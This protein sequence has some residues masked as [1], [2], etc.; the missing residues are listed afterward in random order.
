MTADTIAT[1]HIH[2]DSIA[3]SIAL[4]ILLIVIGLIAL[5][6]PFLA[7]VAFEAIVAWLLVLGGIGHLILAWHVRGAGHHVWE[8]LI[9]VAYLFA[10]IY[11]FLHPVAGLIGLTAILGAYLL[12]KGIFELV[13]GLQIRGARGSGWLIID[14]VISLILA[15]LIWRHLPYSAA[16]MIGTLL[17]I[18]ILFSGISRLALSRGARSAQIPA[19]I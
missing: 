9:G 17:G 15:A 3:W 4:S 18:G 5:I 8:A 11:M 13:A 14:A 1:R 19:V 10:G 7:G 12:F 16:W 6:L 2:Q